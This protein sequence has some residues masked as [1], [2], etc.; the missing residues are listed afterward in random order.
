MRPVRLDFA[1][2]KRGNRL[3]GLSLGT[4]A[5]IAAFVVAWHTSLQEQ[6]ASLEDQASRLERSLHGMAPAHAQ[7]DDTLRAELEQANAVIE[8]LALP[9]DRVFRAVESAA[10]DGIVLKGISPDAKSGKVQITAEAPS[11][12]QMIDYVRRLE[13]QSELANVYLLRHERQGA[14]EGGKVRF[15]VS[16]SWMKEPN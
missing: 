3:K 15:E 5:A 13:Q 7:A 9:W 14:A 8:Q 2:R 16:A 4:A 10:G 6:A 1:T 12:I 11:V